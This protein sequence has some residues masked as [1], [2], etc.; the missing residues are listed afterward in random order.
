MP[1]KIFSKMC[2]KPKFYTYIVTLT[3]VILL[4]FLILMFAPTIFFDRIVNFS[5]N[6]SVNFIIF[7]FLSIIVALILVEIIDF[8]YTKILKKRKYTCWFN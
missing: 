5:S 7:M 2:P 3:I 6:H 8:I 4:N 1:V